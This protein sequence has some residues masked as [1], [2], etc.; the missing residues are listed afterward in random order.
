LIKAGLGIDSFSIISLNEILDPPYDE[1]HKFVK[2][3]KARMIIATE[4]IPPMK[5]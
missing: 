1:K 2:L 5:V 3:A 4:K